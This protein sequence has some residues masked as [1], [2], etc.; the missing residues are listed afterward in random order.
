AVATA[1]VAVWAT[2]FVPAS[3]AARIR[4][5]A[6][7]DILSILASS[8]LMV[9]TFA[10][11][12]M[13][14]AFA[15]AAQSA[16]PR[17]T[18]VLIEDP[19]SQN[20][21]STFLGAFVF[22]MVGL[23]ALGLGYYSRAGEAVL[24]LASGL[25]TALVLVTFFGWLDQLVNMVRL[26]ATVAKIA[27][28]AEAALL[29]RA[30][31]P[32]L[33]GRRRPEAPT[34]HALAA[35]ETGYVRHL[36]MP[37]LQRIAEAAG[38]EIA[39]ASLPGDLASPATALVHTNW[40][41]DDD[42]AAAIRA[43]FTLGQERSFEQDPRF[44]LVV[45]AEIGSRALSPGINDPGT[46]IGVIAVQQRLLTLWAEARSEEAEAPRCPRV[47]VPPLDARNLFEDAFEPLTRDAAPLLE[48][49]LRL[50]HSLAALATLGPAGFARPAQHLSAKAMALAEE[51]LPLEADRARLR[52]AAEKVAARPL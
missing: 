16:T 19:F 15:A 5:G 35:A 43:A 8:M 28:C 30:A 48:V 23:V 34:G 25:V 52:A 6:T 1:L 10:L 3:L 36:D 49:G 2:P 12:A 38:G 24:L 40:R 45:L 51:A 33:G 44:G 20:V 46:A 11:G 29:S 39:V 22:S 41:P 50:Q 9:A 18:R 14:T 37:A 7:W 21:L 32:H 27:D 47:L 42:T 4:D 17:A 13:V 31:A 26:G